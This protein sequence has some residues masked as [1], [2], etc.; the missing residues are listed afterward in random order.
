MVGSVV[1]EGEMVSPGGDA[2]ETWAMNGSEKDAIIR[3]VFARVT[4]ETI[5]A[6]TRIL[7]DIG[8]SASQAFDLLICILNDRAQEAGRG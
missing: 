1:R 8:F 3:A 4:P 2:K 5:L 6:E 7:V